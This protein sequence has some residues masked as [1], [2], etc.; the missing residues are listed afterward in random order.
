[1]FESIFLWLA[2]IS[3]IIVIMACVRGY[4]NENTLKAL[5]VFAGVFM[6]LASIMW[7]LEL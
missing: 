7:R 5:I 6:F 3:E 4:N 1:M 2:I